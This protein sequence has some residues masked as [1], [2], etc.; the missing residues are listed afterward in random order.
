MN[1][2]IARPVSRLLVSLVDD[3]DARAQYGYHL[4]DTVKKLFASSEDWEWVHHVL[5]YVV[6]EIADEDWARDKF[7]SEIWLLRKRVPENEERVWDF[8]EYIGKVLGE[9]GL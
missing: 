4:V 3:A 8:E 1:W 7:R 2:P 5:V 6:C 9:D